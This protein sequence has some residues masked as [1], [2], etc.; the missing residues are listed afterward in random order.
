MVDIATALNLEERGQAK[1][2]VNFGDL[3][4]KFQN[5]IIYA[6]H[7]LIKENPGAVR[8]FVG[9]WLQTIDYARAHKSQTVAFAQQELGVTPGVAGRVYD[10]LMPGSFFSKDGR[11]DPAVLKTMSENFVAMKL[12]DHQADLSQFITDDFLPQAK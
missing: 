12:L 1:I 10:E 6:S 9:G 3:V 11:F 5:Q 4:S 7:K 8:G 2:L